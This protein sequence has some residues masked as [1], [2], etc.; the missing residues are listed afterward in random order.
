MPDLNDTFDFSQ[1]H[2]A[3]AAS[4]AYTD[5]TG[6][7][8]ERS[9]KSQLTFLYRYTTLG[10]GTLVS[11]MTWNNWYD[12]YLIPETEITLNQAI[13][14]VTVGDTSTVQVTAANGTQYSMPT[15]DLSSNTF[16]IRRSQDI[17]SRIVTFGSGSRVTSTALNNMFNQLFKSIQE[18]EQRVVSLENDR[19][20]N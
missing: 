11:D 7:D 6:I 10:D 20:N 12:P 5:L 1:T 2:S 15:F 19:E 13:K 3:T 17:D 16:E 8:D 4:Y 9:H 14:T 18:L